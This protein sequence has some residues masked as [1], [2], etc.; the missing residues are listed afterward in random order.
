MIPNT[1]GFEFEQFD[2]SERDSVRNELNIPLNSVVIGF[3][4]RYSSEKGWD[5]AKE[6]I[7][8][9]QKNKNVEVI[10][11]LGSDRG[12]KEKHIQ[13][14]RYL[15]SLRSLLGDRFHGFVD[16]TGKEVSRLYYAMDFFILTSRRESFGRTA[17]EAMTRKT[18]VLGTNVDGIPE[19]L[20]DKRFVYNN[21]EGAYQTISEFIG[22]SINTRKSKEF[23]FERYHSRFG[24][25]YN[26]ACHDQL[27][28]EILT[29]S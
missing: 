7:E 19:V 29:R 10:V 16:I 5:L 4:A 6:I 21:A 26:I 18:I 3:C 27:Y 17:I 11:V 15:E 14:N 9:F 24:V 28:R 23:F 1:A 22:D 13:I 8:L 25:K 12:G 20:G 2:P